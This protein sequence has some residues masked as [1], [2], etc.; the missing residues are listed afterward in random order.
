MDATAYVFGWES[1]LRDVIFAGS[2]VVSTLLAYIAWISAR[3][4][5]HHRDRRAVTAK[6]E[7]SRALM[8]VG[9][10]GIVLLVTESII[11]RIPSLPVTWESVLYLLSLVLAAA[12]G[13]GMAVNWVRTPTEGREK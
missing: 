1:L 5:A 6:F 7:L 2:L 8:C 11:I 10:A 4:Y 12:G 9:L 3:A 13:L